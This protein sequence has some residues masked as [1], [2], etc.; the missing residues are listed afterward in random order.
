M[1]GHN[2]RQFSVFHSMVPA[3]GTSC[4][5]EMLDQVSAEAVI[6]CYQSLCE[7]S[8][9]MNCPSSFEKLL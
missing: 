4:R 5:T 2:P 3:S 1:S 8:Y 7:T 6:T 9:Q